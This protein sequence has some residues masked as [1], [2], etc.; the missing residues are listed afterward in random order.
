M[1][2]P[3]G[4]NLP[5]YRRPVGSLLWASVCLFLFLFVIRSDLNQK[6]GESF[7][8][9]FIYQWAILPQISNDLFN[10]ISYQFLHADFT[11]LLTNLWYL[12]VFGFILENALGA[13]MFLALSLM[14]GA[15]AVIPEV[16]IQNQPGMPIVGASGAVA[17]MMGA[18]GFMF[19]RAKI[20]FLFLLVPIPNATAT[21]FFPLRYLVYF[22]L[23]LQFSG[24]AY[25][26]LISPRPVAYATHLTGFLIGAFVG[27]VYRKRRDLGFE[28]VDLSGGDLKSF[29]R[30]LK[31]IHE[32]DLDKARFEFQSLSDRY[33][34]WMGLK[35]QLLDVCIRW[36]QPELFEMLW[37]EHSTGILK[38]SRPIELIPLI[39]QY[40][41]TFHKWPTLDLHQSVCLLEMIEKRSDFSAFAADLKNEVHK[42]SK[43]A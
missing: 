11:H 2:L 26:F 23:L 7:E 4:S 33:P 37:K 39:D 28:D 5:F 22:W 15:L 20:R 10:F 43:T 9:S 14:A 31:A 42:L 24:V 30:G 13:R 32:R 34:W 38:R 36:R 19:P 27:L 21:I 12:L 29:Y 41:H 6:M 16:W 1:F 18:V 35:R 40:R 8:S 3:L 25:H 17:F